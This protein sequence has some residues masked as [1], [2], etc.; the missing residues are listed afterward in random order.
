[1]DSEATIPV[2]PDIGKDL[3]T[4]KDAIAAIP[5]PLDTHPD[6][7]LKAWLNIL[8][9]F[10]TAF[11]TYGYVNSWGI[12]QAYYQTNLLGESSTS[13][14]AWIGSIQVPRS[15]SILLVPKI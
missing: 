9:T 14:I 6:G 1:M 2:I 13:A 4:K 15:C 5:E 11:I 3:D 10:M 8:G 7:G 12:F